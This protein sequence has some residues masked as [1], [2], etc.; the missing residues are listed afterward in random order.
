MNTDAPI[1]NVDKKR[2]SISSLQCVDSSSFK[3]C[4][5]NTG[6]RMDEARKSD[7]A[8]ED[9]I[10]FDI[11]CNG[12]NLYNVNNT[13]QFSTAPKTEI[14]PNKTPNA[15]FQAFD[16]KSYKGVLH[17]IVELF[18]QGTNLKRNNLIFH[19]YFG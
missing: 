18:L 17:S 5:T 1:K 7:V 8:K 4:A 16:G 12:L 15:Y 2:R 13:R 10:L 6:A 11:R 14:T 9:K 19:L 3:S